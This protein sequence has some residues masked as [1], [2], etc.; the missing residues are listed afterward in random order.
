[1]AI[2]RYQRDSDFGVYMEGSPFEG[3]FTIEPTVH[4]PTQ[5]RF[6]FTDAGVTTTITMAGSGLG[7]KFGGGMITDIT[8]GTITSISSADNGV[9]W[10]L[11]TGL[12]YSAAAMFDYAAANNIAAQIALVLGGN[13]AIYGTDVAEGDRIMGAGGNDTLYGYNGND[14]ILGGDGRDR[15]IGGAGNDLLSGGS[16][17]DSF[18][19][20]TRPNAST[21]A[22]RI[23]GFSHVADSIQLENAVFIAFT[24]AGTMT[25]AAFRTGTAAADS[26][27]RIIYNSTTG[28]IYYDADGTLTTASKVLFATVTPG[29]VLDHTDFIII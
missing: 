20:N 12:S 24:A 26:S 13:D 23:T 19:F 8:G 7:Y 27:D 1:M 10:G 15:L 16:G 9:V 4:T 21:N 5:L 22:D 29:T 2:W 11:V 28:K 25:A 3:I 17:A 14:T 6:A 18:V